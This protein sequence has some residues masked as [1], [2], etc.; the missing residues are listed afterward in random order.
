VSFTGILLLGELL[1]FLV[2]LLLLLLSFIFLLI[3]IWTIRNE[4][5]ILAI[6]V[7]SSLDS[8]SQLLFLVSLVILLFLYEIL[9][10]SNE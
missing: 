4:V 6:I 7:A 5:S 9:K 2:A 8:C 3:F 1:V 10:S